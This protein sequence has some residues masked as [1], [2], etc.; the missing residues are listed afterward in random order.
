MPREGRND[1]NENW[2][3]ELEGEEEKCI[4]ESKKLERNEGR[5]RLGVQPSDLDIHSEF[6]SR[7]FELKVIVLEV[8]LSN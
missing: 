5:N 8:E 6:Y 7:P 4:A 1:R 2:W 3:E